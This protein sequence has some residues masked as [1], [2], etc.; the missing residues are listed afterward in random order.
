MQETAPVLLIPNTAP[1]S[2]TTKSTTKIPNI[3][4]AFK[5]QSIGRLNRILPVA[6]VAAPSDDVD[7]LAASM[8][9]SDNL[10]QQD[11]HDLQNEESDDVVVAQENNDEDVE[12]EEEGELV[13]STKTVSHATSNLQKLREVALQNRQSSR[14]V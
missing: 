14:F 13:N 10:T 6:L 9:E 1:R 2:F 3:V 4:R 8:I 5:T 11:E 7:Y 12:D